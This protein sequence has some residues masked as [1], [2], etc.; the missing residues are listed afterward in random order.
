VD[1]P[2]VDIQ[3]SAEER[4][5]AAIITERHDGLAAECSA[6]RKRI[7]SAL[8]LRARRGEEIERQFWRR[9]YA[10]GVVLSVRVQPLERSVQVGCGREEHDV[11][12]EARETKA[13]CE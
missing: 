8:T 5:A 1:D 13:M 3:G 10:L 11:A 2:L 7:T 9:P 12:L 4:A 6:R